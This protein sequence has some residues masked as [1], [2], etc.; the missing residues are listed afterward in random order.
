MNTNSKLNCSI[1]IT[2]CDSYSDVWDPFFNLFFKYWPDC[3]FPIYIT[4][5][6][7]ETENSRVTTIKLGKD[8]HWASN[9]KKALKSINTP[10]VLCLIEDYFLDSKVDTK[11]IL[12]LINIIKKEKAG[13]LRLF[14]HPGP[15]KEFKKFKN[16]GEI[17]VNSE[18]RTSLMAAIWEKDTLNKLLVG[19]ETAW[20]MEIAGTKRSKKINK[21]FLSVT[22][23]NYA[24]SYYT[25]IIRQGKWTKK[26]KEVIKTEGIKID[27]KKRP[28]LKEANKLS[29]IINKSKNV[30]RKYLQRIKK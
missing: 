23:D 13:Y 11:N 16:I 15:D 3:P 2:S 18:Y 26:V 1:L 21:K 27:F 29:T 6:F 19:G 25:G 22:T 12:N 20:D 7:L 4:S 28:F 8:K 17:E 5:N 10:Y 9:T 14:P 24:L 30:I